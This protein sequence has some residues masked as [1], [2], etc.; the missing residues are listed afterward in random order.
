M[1]EQRT[2]LATRR[3]DLVYNYIV[4][5]RKEHGVSPSYR[6]IMEDLNLY[7]EALITAIDNLGTDGRIT[8]YRNRT[9]GL[10]YGL[11]PTSE[12]QE[13][14]RVQLLESAC[15]LWYAG[16]DGSEDYQRAMEMR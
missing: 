7:T 6:V 5:Y 14:N 8:F 1:T 13:K 12:L 3:M 10:R 11:I 2:D 16:K 9:S 4:A 15:A